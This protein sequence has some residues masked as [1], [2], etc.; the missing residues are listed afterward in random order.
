MNL[1]IG[2]WDHILAI[3]GVDMLHD[4]TRGAAYFG[5]GAVVTHYCHRCRQ[6]YQQ[7]KERNVS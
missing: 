5:L 6:W 3:I 1:I 7:R 4:F 2:L